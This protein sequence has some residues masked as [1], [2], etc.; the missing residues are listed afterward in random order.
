MAKVLFV[1]LL[2][3]LVSS[4]NVKFQFQGTIAH[5]KGLRTNRLLTLQYSNTQILE[6]RQKKKNYWE[7]NRSKES[8]K[9][10][11]SLLKT[12]DRAIAC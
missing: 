5:F 12:A 6:E 11:K 7:K 2:F 9:R 8:F 10:K 3:K 4:C 1:T